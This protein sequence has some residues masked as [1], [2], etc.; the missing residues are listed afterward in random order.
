MKRRCQF[1]HLNGSRGV[2]G[3]WREGGGVDGRKMKRGIDYAGLISILRAGDGAGVA[4]TRNGNG[5]RSTGR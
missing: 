3:G 1:S 2:P 4:P 5:S